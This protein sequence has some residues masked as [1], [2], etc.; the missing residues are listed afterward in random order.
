MSTRHFVKAKWMPGIDSYVVQFGDAYLI[1][2]FEG[3]PEATNAVKPRKTQR[4]SKSVKPIGG[5]DNKGGTNTTSV[6]DVLGSVTEDQK[7]AIITMAADG[8]SI[9]EIKSAL[10][11]LSRKQII[12]FI[13]SYNGQTPTITGQVPD[14][15]G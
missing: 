1:V 3:G 2:E 5:S 12:K 15:G 10:P 7:V 6:R 9:K 14:Q 13:E 11:K 8:K 4:T